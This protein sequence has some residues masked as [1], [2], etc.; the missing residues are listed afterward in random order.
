MI[1]AAIFCTNLLLVLVENS[2][3]NFIGNP[4]TKILFAEI[5]VITSHIR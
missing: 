4:S 3:P 5:P 2:A 1:V